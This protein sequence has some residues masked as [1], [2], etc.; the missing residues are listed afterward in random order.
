MTT[1]DR[2][3]TIKT[4]MTVGEDGVLKLDVAPG[5]YEVLLVRTNT[6]PQ[7]P[8]HPSWPPD[9]WERVTITDPAFRRYRQDD[10]PDTPPLDAG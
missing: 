4:W 2:P 5:Y 1:D 10:P 3:T 6:P 7:L 8:P 9:F